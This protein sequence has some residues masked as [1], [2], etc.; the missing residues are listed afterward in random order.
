MRQTCI[1][2]CIEYSKLGLK[3]AEQ[4]LKGLPLSRASC[5]TQ[6]RGNGA[7]LDKAAFAL[8]KTGSG[9]SVPLYDEATRH[10]L[11]QFKASFSA[12]SLGT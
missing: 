6:L 8:S 9:K 3:S 2:L 10:R 4:F 11:D 7:R 5:A 12:I 1:A